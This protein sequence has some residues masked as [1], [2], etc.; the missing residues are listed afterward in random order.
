MATPRKTDEE[1]HPENYFTSP[2]GHIR[3]RIILNESPEVPKEGLFVGLNGYQILIKPNVEVDIPRPVRLMLDN[4]IATETTQS[5]DER[6][7]I[8]DH[9]RH[10]RRFTYI[11]VKEDVNIPAPEVIDNVAK[12][13]GDSVKFP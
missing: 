7:N 9:H 8:I 1:L 6:G 13:A 10:M 2:I 5:N 3:D 4:R 12:E 11:L